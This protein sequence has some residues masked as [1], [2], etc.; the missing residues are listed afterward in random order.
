V[1]VVLLH[2]FVSYL[3]K[4]I[5]SREHSIVVTARQAAWVMTM[6]QFSWAGVAQER[7][8]HS[9]TNRELLA[10]VD[11]FSA[12]H[13]TYDFIANFEIACLHFATT[14]DAAK[15]NLEAAKLLLTTAV[16]QP[17]LPSQ[18]MSVST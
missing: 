6:L 5:V 2:N 13:W 18:D 15:I 16:C 4:E 3:W 8:E 14:S 17:R 7:N 12:T 11:T 1:D 9:P 10:R